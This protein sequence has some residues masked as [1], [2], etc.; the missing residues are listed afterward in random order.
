MLLTSLIHVQGMGLAVFRHQVT[1]KSV[2]SALLRV[3]TEGSFSAAAKRVSKQI[4]SAKRTALQETVGEGTS[5][6]C[7]V[8]GCSVI[9]WAGVTQQ[10]FSN[11]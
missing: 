1:A 11:W 7:N 10:G 8:L 4:R 9:H 5:P 2:H 3:L 6:G